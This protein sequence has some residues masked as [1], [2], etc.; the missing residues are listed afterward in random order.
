MIRKTTCCGIRE[1]SGLQS[2]PQRTLIKFME[3]RRGIL[4]RSAF[5]LFSDGA[6]YGQSSKLEP[7]IE[8]IE[9]NKLGTVYSTEYHPN[10]NS[11]RNVKGVLLALNEPN[12]SDWYK[13]QP[14][15]MKNQFRLESFRLYDTYLNGMYLCEN[16]GFSLAILVWIVFAYLYGFMIGLFLEDWSLLAIL[17]P[18]AIAVSLAIIE[19][20]KYFFKYDY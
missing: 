14:K 12:F 13:K 1:F 17:I 2:T 4:F 20:F 5:Y 9:E 19:N 8:Y 3:E 11:G 10:P 7:L 18:L 6:L 15:E 16:I